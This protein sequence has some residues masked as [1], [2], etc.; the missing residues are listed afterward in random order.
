MELSYIVTP[1]IGG[2]I[3]YLTN[4]MAIIVFF[5]PQ[6]AKY[7]L[8]IHVPFTPGIIPRYKDHL[9][10]SIGET[11]SENL[12]NSETLEKY[13]LSDEMI[14][15]LRQSVQSF[16]EEQKVNEET[17]RQFLL[18]YLT[19]EEISVITDNINQNLTTQINKKITSS[20]V[21]D[22]IAHVVVE[23]VIDKMRSMDPT[24][25]ISNLATGFFGKSVNAFVQFGSNI[26]GQ[27]FNLLKTPAE[28]LVASNI[29]DTLRNN[30][31]EIISGMVSEEITSL[32]DVKIC[33]LLDGK[34]E[35]LMQIP[36]IVENVYRT[37]ITEHMPHILE[38]IDISHIISGRIKEMDM[39]EIEK[40]VNQ[41][42]NKQLKA[43]IWFGAAIGVIF[44]F[45]GVLLTTL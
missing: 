43:I 42:M 22:K 3:G 14:G 27:F 15:K 6:K 35:Q 23:Q 40:V 7:F 13:L 20:V 37:V 29:N 44:A 8:G 34:E 16:I 39:T 2:I 31:T 25:F 41:V 38:T 24:E 32:L 45:V 33:Q 18:H 30:G 21:G 10:E 36:G 9:S 5:R 1:L 12:M 28:Q 11:I 26:V 19:E 17:V 4:Y